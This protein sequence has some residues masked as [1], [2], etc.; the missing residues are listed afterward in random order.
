MQGL[1]TG[2]DDYVAKPF[3]REELIQLLSSAYQ[4]LHR[5]AIPREQDP[6][7]KQKFREMREYWEKNYELIDREIYRNKD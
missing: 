6:S 3:D 5:K 1:Q 2:A 4:D 7:K